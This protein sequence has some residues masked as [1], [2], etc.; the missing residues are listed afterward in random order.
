MTFLYGLVGWNPCIFCLQIQFLDWA[1]FWISLNHLVS[2]CRYI[3]AIILVTCAPSPAVTPTIPTTTS[4]TSV[5]TPWL[6]SITLTAPGPHSLLDSLD[7]LWPDSPSLWLGRRPAVHW[8]VVL[9]P[10]SATSGAG[11]LSWE[12]TGPPPA[13]TLHSAL[14]LPDKAVR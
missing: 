13:P 11:G 6:L 1:L 3:L 7:P 12:G 2:Q 8:V 10:H 5:A 14:T 4:R 9:P